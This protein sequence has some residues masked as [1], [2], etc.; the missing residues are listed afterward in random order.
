MHVTKILQHL[1]EKA[2]FLLQFK[3]F[4]RHV[5]FRLFTWCALILEADIEGLLV[6]FGLVSRDLYAH[7][8]GP[9]QHPPITNSNIHLKVKFTL[10][11]TK[12]LV[13]LTLPFHL[14]QWQN[15]AAI[16]NGILF[17]AKV[18]SCLPFL[19]RK[20]SNHHQHSL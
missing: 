11:K 17:P 9:K 16:V 6:N 10:W 18:C 2:T 20:L 7:Q 13:G 14:E 5:Y 4:N 1:K 12:S 8:K 3:Y 15:H 19:V